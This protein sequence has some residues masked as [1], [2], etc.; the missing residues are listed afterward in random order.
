MKF[1][2]G[3]LCFTSYLRRRLWGNVFPLEPNTPVRPAVEIKLSKLVMTMLSCHLN[4]V[5]QLRDS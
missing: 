1:F 2:K 4:P 5:Y 3:K